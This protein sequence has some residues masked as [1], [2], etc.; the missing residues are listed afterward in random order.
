LTHFGL[1]LTY[2]KSS[3]IGFECKNVKNITSEAAGEI[4]KKTFLQRKILKIWDYE[5]Q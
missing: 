5:I 1:F 2:P 4:K 3:N